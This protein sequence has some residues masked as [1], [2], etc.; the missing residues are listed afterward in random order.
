MAAEF[1]YDLNGHEVQLIEIISR[2]PETVQQAAEEYRPLIMA[3]YLYDLA[4]SF[5]SFY[6]AVPVIQAEARAVR[7]ARLRLVAAARQAIRNALDLLDI[8]APDVM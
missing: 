5:H 8:K 1:D 7:A 3:G 2:F 6:H 4:N